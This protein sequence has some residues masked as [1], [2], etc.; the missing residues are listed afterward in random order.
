M[1]TLATVRAIAGAVT[2]RNG[3]PCA[4]SPPLPPSARGEGGEGVEH[5][6]IVR[7]REHLA[8]GVDRQ[9]ADLVDLVVRR[10]RARRAA[11]SP[12]SA[13][14]WAGPGGRCSRCPAAPDRGCS[15]GRTPRPPRARRCAPRRGRRDRP[16]PSGTSSRRSRG[17]ARG[18]PRP[19]HRRRDPPDHAA[20]R[21]HLGRHQVRNH[22]VTFLPD[23]A[24]HAARHCPR[25]SAAST[26]SAAT[27]RPAT[28][29]C[30]RL[31]PSA[32]A[33]RSHVLGHHG[34]VLVAEHALQGGD[35][36]GVRR[37]LRQGAGG[38]LGGV[39]GPL[40]AD[41][42]TS[43]SSSSVGSRPRLAGLAAELA[44]RLRTTSSGSTFAA[45]ASAASVSFGS[46][47]ASTRRSSR[48]R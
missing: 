22:P 8:D 2:V 17:G 9:P 40:G 1:V 39:A 7:V 46:R 35:G 25:C 48:A 24:S 34:V 47:P 21:P 33:L 44:P 18:A 19:A 26:R 5:A 12:S 15:A 42:Q 27:S 38:R 37:R 36:G 30:W 43:C 41:A 3:A 14:A 31:V 13:R 32:T 28:N 23:A 10:E 4:V 29:A 11:A 20:G 16:C 45:G 6:A